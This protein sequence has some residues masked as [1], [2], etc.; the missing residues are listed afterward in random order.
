MK[1]LRSIVLDGWVVMILYWL[2][3][4]YFTISG[5]G[6]KSQPI[7]CIKTKK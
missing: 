4:S 5:N 2:K 1:N 3:A 6:Y 7:M